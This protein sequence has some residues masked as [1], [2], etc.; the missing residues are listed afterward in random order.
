M[1]NIFGRRENLAPNY[2]VLTLL[3]LFALAPIAILFFNSLKSNMEIGENSITFPRE[4]IWTNYPEAWVQG[5][6]AVTMTNSAIFVLGT[7]TCVIVLGGLAAYA[8]ARLNPRG[9]GI[10]MIYMLTLSTIPFWLFAVPLFILWRNL[11]LLN[12]RLGLI[13]IYAALNSPFA[14]FLLRSFLVKFPSD[15]E[16]AARVDGAKE[17]QVLTRVVL[18]IMWPSLLTV[19]LVVALGVWGE[20]QIALIFMQQDEMMPITTSYFN[21]MRRFS[22]DWSL[23]SAGAVM[24]ILPVLII[25]MLLQRRFVEGL[26]QGGLK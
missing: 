21:F 14:I 9:S 8:L 25:F 15:L 24:M 10:Y 19:A 7:V 13:V 22:R 18:P 20:F 17:W 12:T 4:I 1:H 2:I 11:A 26:T 3:C 16:D 5:K 23:T 6:F